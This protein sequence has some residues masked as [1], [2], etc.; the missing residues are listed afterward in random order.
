MHSYSEITDIGEPDLQQPSTIIRK[1]SLL[2]KNS[3]DV[4]SDKRCEKN[5][6]FFAN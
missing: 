3:P 4:V 2:G 1:T 6:Q 5:P